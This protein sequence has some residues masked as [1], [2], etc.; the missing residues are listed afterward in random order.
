M[1]EDDAAMAMKEMKF[2]MYRTANRLV[3]KSEAAYVGSET[4]SA[5]VPAFLRRKASEG[6][7]R[8]P[9]R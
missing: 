3:A 7:G 6:Q 9:G 8:K 5:D 4:D 2:S 1:L